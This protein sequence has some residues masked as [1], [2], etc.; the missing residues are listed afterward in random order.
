MN[1]MNLMNLMDLMNL[2]NDMTNEMILNDIKWLN[3]R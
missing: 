1:L 2:M 3:E